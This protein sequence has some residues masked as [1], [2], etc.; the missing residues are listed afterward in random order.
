MKMPQMLSNPHSLTHSL[1]RSTGHCWQ[2]IVAYHSAR[3][4]DWQPQG[5]TVS[6]HCSPSPSLSREEKIV[7]LNRSFTITTHAQTVDLCPLFKVEAILLLIF[8]SWF[9][10]F[11]FHLCVLEMSLNGAFA[12]PLFKCACLQ[13]GKHWCPIWCCGWPLRGNIRIR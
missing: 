3:R 11:T 6:L 2:P 12:F 13:V 9:K 5:Y 4:G 8:W 7:P 1:A 10:L